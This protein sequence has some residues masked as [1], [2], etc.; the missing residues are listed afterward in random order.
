MSGWKML[1]ESGG[2]MDQYSFSYVLGSHLSVHVEQCA[3]L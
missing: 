2:K 3:A 1:T